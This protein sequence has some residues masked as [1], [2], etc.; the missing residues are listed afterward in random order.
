MLSLTALALAFVAQSG[1]GAV[2]ADLDPNRYEPGIL[3][4]INFDSDIGF[5]FGALGVLA[6]FEEGCEPYSWRLQ[7]LLFAAAKTDAT[8]KLGVPFHKDVVQIDVPQFLDPSLRL[9]AAA[10]FRKFSNAAFYGLGNRSERRTFTDAELEADEAARRFHRFDHTIPSL[11]ANLRWEVFGDL[12]LIGGAILS[13]S[14]V[15]TFGGSLLES[16]LARRGDGTADGDVLADLLLGD[17]DHLLGLVNL[18]LL[19]DSRD[20][21]FT[22]TS[23]VFSEV[24]MRLSPGLMK[25]LRYAGFYGSAA[26]FVPIL[27]S[28]LVGAARVATDIMVG[29]VPF[30]EQAR[31][32]V[33]WPKYGPGGGDS[34]RGELLQRYYGKIR[35]L[36]NFELRGM[37]PSWR[38][39]SSFIRLGG[40]AFVD[41]GRV[42][43]DFQ[44]RTV[45]GASL[46]GDRLFDLAVGLGGGLRVQWG[47][48][49]IIRADY[50]VSATEGTSGLYIDVGQVF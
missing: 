24:A 12:E 21:E 13:F 30:Y 47:E 44:S 34:L 5:G 28:H 7:A 38:I 11:T 10:E 16:Q 33:L 40:I 37:L 17:E 26:G 20:H 19:Y 1:D 46:D 45:D 49:F 23:G 41:T 9:F 50:A 43:A 42:W 48:T 6:K 2:R 27:G 14:R 3:P 29:N 36:G 35:V 39:G 8:G 15:R 31:F 18:G 4:A 32:G 22:P 25:R